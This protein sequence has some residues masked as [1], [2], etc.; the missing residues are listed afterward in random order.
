MLKKILLSDIII[1]TTYR[2]FIGA[3]AIKKISKENLRHAELEELEFMR[4]STLYTEKEIEFIL[5]HLFRDEQGDA[6]YASPYTL[7]FFKL[8]GVN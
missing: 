5:D 6:Y 8:Y 3:Y 1:K 4:G 2:C 7:G